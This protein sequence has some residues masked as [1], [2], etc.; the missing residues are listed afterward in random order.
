MEEKKGILTGIIFRSESDGYTIAEME[1]EN[2]LLTVVGN[3]PSA[4]KGT[5][6]LLRGEFIQHPRYG[7]QFA[8]REAQQVL[9]STA[10]EIMKF[11]SSG[12]IRGVGEKTAAAI[13]E[14]F[15]ADTLKI[16]GETPARL[17]EVSGIGKKTAEK[18]AAS[19]AEH[20][21]YA[22]V[23]MFFQQYGITSGQTMVLYKAY[24]KK[25][26]D[27]VTENPYR[28]ADEVRGI[29]F[30][31]A[32]KIAAAM[33]TEPDNPFRIR[34]GIRYCL[35]DAADRGSTYLPQEELLEKTAQLLDLTRD[36]VNEVLV[37]AAFEG[38][39]M[40][41]RIGEIPV[42]YLDNYYRAEQ[43][44]AR[45]IAAL[46]SA[47]VKPL[48]EDPES[49]IRM[50]SAETG[51][52]LSEEQEDAVRQ[53][54]NTGFSVITGGPGTGKT[55]IIRT[56]IRIFERSGLK[57]ALAAPTGRAA[58]RMTETSGR[59][60]VTVHRLLEYTPDEDS[61]LMFFGKDAED[62][63]DQDV[64]IVDEASMI[65]LLLMDGLLDA[66]VPG[67]RLILVGDADQLP[68][69]GA[70]AVLTD[71]IESGLVPVAR[72]K[73]IFR[74]AQES[75]IVMNAHRINEGEYPSANGKDTDFFLMERRNERSIR[76]LIVQLVTSRLPKYYEADSL[77]DIQVLTPIHRGT[78]GTDEM[79]R[80]LQDAFNPRRED[81]QEKAFGG[82]IF[83]EGDKVM[84]TKNNYE[85]IWRRP[86]DPDDHK[87]VYNGDLGFVD[88]VDEEN[89]TLTVVFD[90]DKYARYDILT[91]RE[92]EL[93][94]AITV[95]KSQG[96]EFPIVVMPIASFPAML[97]TRN[98]LYTA[99]TRGKKA[100]V[101]VGTENRVR[102]MI[103]NDRIRLRYSGLNERLSKMVPFLK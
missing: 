92:L 16:M 18:I 27:I 79:N 81:R 7:E 8:F 15:G 11:L 96:S 89:G 20:Y 3:L 26:V 82:K 28:L 9:P 2:E 65:D 87:G 97:A 60:A 69:V 84:Q 5:S 59:P 43:S 77:R 80:V 14:K 101:L 22:Q 61:G 13:V 36:Q 85:M 66:V 4:E 86:G 57:V 62:P 68:P 52:T 25:A 33:G 100:V 98:L 50:A 30:M 47:Q 103:D 74:Q 37:R 1:T 102:A 19:Y 29:G 41:D 35:M 73:K 40:I 44:A 24:G 58:K 54:L 31:K 93:A 90:E 94:Y 32:D 17:K 63:L 10:D 39:M 21:D 55:T 88:T 23:A 75:M 78:V 42:V 46:A 12:V 91:I 45:Q 53:S 48:N 49:G 76:D 6:Y 64:I 70:G 56:I 51:L 71:I 95:H 83:R 67:T 38:D 72:L 34:S 99:I